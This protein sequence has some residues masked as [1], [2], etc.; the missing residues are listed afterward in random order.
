M[1]RNLN[2]TYAGKRIL[3]SPYVG[4]LAATIA[5]ETAEGDQGPGILYNESIDPAYA[6][7]YLR[8][9]ITNP[10]TVGTL[11]VSENG[12]IEGYDLPVGT[13]VFAYDLIVNDAYDSSSS[14][15]VAVGVVNAVAEGGVGVGA[16]SGTGGE[17]AGQVAGT[18]DGG[19]GSGTGSGTGGEAAGEIS[20]T[21]EGGAG[22]GTGSGT[23]GDAIGEAGGSATV[24]GGTGTGTGS[25]TGGEA[26]GQ[27]S[28]TTEGG[29]GT[30]TGSGSGGEAVGSSAD[31]VAEG[32]TGVGTGSG[33]GG[34]AV[35]NADLI[36]AASPDWT[37][38]PSPRTWIV[39]PPRRSWIIKKA[40]GNLMPLPDKD[41]EEIKTVTFDFSDDATAL[42]DAIVTT[43]A[44]AGLQDASPGDVLGAK[45]LDGGKVHQRVQAG[46]SGTS[47]ALRCKA[48]DADGEVH[49]AVALLP[50]K[51]AT[52]A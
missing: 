5:A 22:V 45:T 20:A 2:A 21:A 10:P 38:K 35:G 47:Y 46:Q 12:A 6:G 16:G 40:K 15:T 51:T 49:V 32:G 26:S 3:A 43:S 31:A 34:S 37:L 14:F 41:P 13:H 42:S 27:V 30:G 52:P 24:A 11:R 7:K 19:T 50:V 36:T 25:G 33:V 39:A 17:A 44:Y 28:A 1:L 29:T 23:G 48:I 18:A 8:A 4:V 9:W